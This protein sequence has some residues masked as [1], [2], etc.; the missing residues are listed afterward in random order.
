MYRHQEDQFVVKIV[1]HTKI[2]A[3]RVCTMTQAFNVFVFNRF[4]NLHGT[5]YVTIL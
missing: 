4:K 3:N 5:L 1:I 2:V